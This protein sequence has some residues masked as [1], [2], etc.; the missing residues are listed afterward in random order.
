MLLSEQALP[1]QHKKASTKCAYQFK[2]TDNVG[3]YLREIGRV[4]LLT[5][6]QE[7]AYGK[8]VQQLVYLLE[9]KETLAKKLC[10][11]PMLAEW[12]LHVNL[13]EVQLK[14]ILRQ[15]QRAKQKMVE[16]NLRLV[17]VIAKR[18]Q[19]RGLELSDLIQEGSMGLQRGVEKFDPTR[20]YKFSTYAYW[21]VTQAITRAIA[22][23]S[24]TIRLPSH[25]VE[26]LNKIKKAQRWLSQQLGRMPTIS[27]IAEELELSANQIRECLTW[28][29]QTISLNLLVGDEQN[30]ELAELLEDTDKIPEDFVVE[31]CSFSEINRLMSDLTSQQQEVLALRF[32]LVDEQPLTLAQI[33][34]HLNLSRERIRQIEQKALKRLRQRHQELQLSSEEGWNPD[35]TGDYSY[36]KTGYSTDH[37][38]MSLFDI[39][40][41]LV[42]SATAP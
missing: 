40:A 19:E 8:Q 35:S 31:S 12:A 3:S 32:G 23:Q 20:G 1:R 37:Q 26:K 36:S 16:A 33:S 10:C 30:T 22:T 2:G 42:M 18:Y 34:D 27:E 6:E 9:A 28:K 13:T 38:Q 21:W 24:R 29:Q 5:R 4:P 25:I 7:I 17:V 11:E 41:L 39:D 15:G 14:E